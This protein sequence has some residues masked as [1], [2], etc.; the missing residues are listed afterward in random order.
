MTQIDFYTHVDNKLH[1]ACQLV[2]KAYRQKLR[3]LV[4]TP[5]AVTSSKL[6]TMLWTTPAIDFLPHAIAG[7]RLAAETPIIID[8]QSDDLVHDQLLVN[9]RDQW[10]PFFSRFQR[11]IEIVSLD[12]NDRLAARQRYGFYRDRGYPI[13]SHNL[14]KE[15][16]D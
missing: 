5:D 7:S 14:G 11:L 13:K 1:T 9:L 4:F 3:I 8:H 15:T 2:A 12:E 16:S 6:D 10:P